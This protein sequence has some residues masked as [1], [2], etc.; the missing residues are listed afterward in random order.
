MP[1]DDAFRGGGPRR[2]RPDILHLILADSVREARHL[3]V[4]QGWPRHRAVIIDHVEKI[5]GYTGPRID[6]NSSVAFHDISM[7]I[8][9]I[10]EEIREAARVRGFVVSKS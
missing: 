5:L 2:G 4:T 3:M 10:T 9:P 6:P 8:D 1:R 7:R